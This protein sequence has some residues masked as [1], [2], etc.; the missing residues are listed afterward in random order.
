M[1]GG[2]VPRP[3][4]WPELIA[5]WE[6]TPQQASWMDLREGSRCAWCKCNLRSS[7]LA[8]G[9]V[10]AINRM[11]GGNASSLRTALARRAVGALR[12]AE[13]N[14]AGNLHGTLKRFD[15]LRYSE[16]GSRYPAIP[17]E[18]LMSL[19]FDDATFDLVITSD[20]LEHVPDVD[21]A[22]REVRRVLVLGGAHVF[23]VPMVDG[24]PTRKRAQLQDGKVVHLL[25]PSYHGRADDGGADWLVFNEFGT[26]FI[27][28]CADAGFSVELITD[29]HNPTA[30]VILATKA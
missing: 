6:L 16:F 3:V 20:T 23:T 21:L 4:L 27:A 9:L 22:L 10:A 14:K 28:R 2:H 11:V 8:R 1:R 5:Q 15:G 25:P 7:Q 24:R 12:V 18:D 26:D 13:I 19:S 29:D 17:S 30:T